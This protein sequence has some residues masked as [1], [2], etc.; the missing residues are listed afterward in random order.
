MG[1]CVRARS[2]LL[3]AS[4]F[5]SSPCPAR[6]VDDSFEYDPAS[7]GNGCHHD[8]LDAQF[9]SH[10][11]LFCS[12]GALDKVL[13]RSP[14]VYAR[15]VDHLEYILREGLPAPLVAD[16]SQR[17]LA[18]LSGL[19]NDN[20]TAS[21]LQDQL[22]AETP[23]AQSATGTRNDITDTMQFYATWLEERVRCCDAVMLRAL[24]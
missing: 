22:V 2:A 20:E 23:A 3:V 15:Y 6:A 14:D 5:S 12:E 11:L 13:V 17:Q 24:V 10:R 18:D 19:L 1:Q 21:G 7:K 16:V 8:S 9:D 4:A